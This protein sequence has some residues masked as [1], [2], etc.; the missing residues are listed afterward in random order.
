MRLHLLFLIGASACF[1]GRAQAQDHP[2]RQTLSPEARAHV[3]SADTLLD[4][5]TRPLANARFDPN[6]GVLRAAYR[7][8]ERVGSPASPVE[9]ALAYIRAASEEF[10][11]PKDGSDLDVVTVRPGTYS[12]HVTLQQTFRGLPVYNRRV[13]ISLDARLQPTMAVSGYAPHLSADPDFSTEPGLSSGAASQM[14]AEAVSTGISD[15]SPPELV[16][17]PAIPVK[18]AWRIVAHP[19]GVPAEWEI[20]LNARTGALIQ[21]LDLTVHDHSTAPI[22]D[23]VEKITRSTPPWSEVARQGRR[24]INPSLEGGGP[25]GPEGVALPYTPSRWRDSPLQATV[26]PAFS[27]AT[28]HAA[29]I[30]GS[31]LVF[32]PDPL[33]TAG[34]PYGGT[35]TDQ[36]DADTPELTAQLKTVPLRDLT[37]RNG[38]YRLEGPYV[39]ITGDTL[40]GGTAYTPPAE[41]DPNAFRYTRSD[42]RFEAVMAYYHIDTAQ[43][44]VQSL[45]MGRPIHDY[46]IRVNPH[47]FDQ[48]DNSNF[49]PFKDAIAFGEGGIDDAEDAAVIWHE[50]AHALLEADDPGLI[51]SGGESLALHEGWADYWADSYVRNLIETGAVPARDWRHLFNWDGNN[52][53]WCGRTLDH[54][55]HYPDDVAYDPPD[56]CSLSLPYQKGLLWATTTMEIYTALG[57]TVSDRLNLAS[58][59]YLGVPATMRDAAEAILQA[60]ADL[61]GGSHTDALTTILGSRGFLGNVVPQITHTPVQAVRDVH[62]SLV[63]DVETAEGSAPIDSVYAYYRAGAGPFERIVL[64]PIDGAYQGALPLPGYPADMDYYLEAVGASGTRTL[65]PSTAPSSVFSF[66]VGPDTLALYSNFPEPFSTQTRIVYRIPESGHVTLDLYD[67]LG[68]RVLQLLDEQEDAGTHTFMLE[69]GRLAAGSYFLHMHVSAVQKVEPILVVH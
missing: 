10:G 33:T 12:S 54:P 50:Y 64:Q 2:V 46:P 57:R 25:P 51:S 65:L 62:G 66:P 41:T 8:H 63:I 1:A 37:F 43:R 44:Y 45:G 7:V 13:T 14:A 15:T 19:N 36:N 40:V 61:Y 21:V 53:P 34:V 31:G 26:D 52:P 4:F 24:A 6:A 18:L 69:A 3:V 38:A 28:A 42:D 58:H 23:N 39:Q 68:R 17:Y 27:T 49:F 32:D 55:G 60:D 11:W 20:L 29:A 16:V 59:A 9:A 35:Y 5:Q 48:Q 47:G 30:D 56:G 67:V 22:S